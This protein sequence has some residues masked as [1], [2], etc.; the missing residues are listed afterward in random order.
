[1]TKPLPLTVGDRVM[2]VRPP[3]G[4][5]IGDGGPPIGTHGTVI[6]SDK[7]QD[8]TPVRWDGW[9]GGWSEGDRSRGCWAFLRQDLRKLPDRKEGA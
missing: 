2:R 4:H 3:P 1:M 7:F 6:K 9:P 5:Y 8:A